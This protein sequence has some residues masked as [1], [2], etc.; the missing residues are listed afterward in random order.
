MRKIVSIIA[1]LC[2]VA[3]TLFA[4]SYTNNTYHKLAEEYTEK[5]EKALDA[6]YYEL[7][8][9]YA[10]EAKKNAALSEEFIA[11]MMAKTAAEES[12]EAAKARIDYA[13]KQGADPE[14]R[15]MK[16]ALSYLNQAE[17]DFSDENYESAKTNADRVMAVLSDDYLAELAAKKAAEDAKVNAAAALERA[18][19]AIDTAEEAGM[20]DT[21]PVYNAAQE[22]Y[23]SALKNF[24]DEN[25]ADSIEDSEKV[26][27]LLTPPEKI[28]EMVESAKQEAAEAVERAREALERAEA[29]GADKSRDPYKTALEDYQKAVDELNEGKYKAAKDDAQKVLDALDD[30]YFDVLDAKTAAEEAIGKAKARLDEVA[31]NGMSEDDP[32]YQDA[33][34]Y[35]DQAV[36]DF[37]DG[38]YADAKDNAEQ[39]IALLADVKDG[40]SEDVSDEVPV[41]NEETGKTDESETDGTDTVK[42]G[43]TGEPVTEDV[44][45]TGKTDSES[46]EGSESADE[47]AARA[48]ARDAIAKAKAAI[49]AAEKAGLSPDSDLYHK[50]NND[51]EKAVKAYGNGEYG[52][53]KDYAD[54]VVAALTDEAL[55]EARKQ[56]E[57]AEAIAAARERI[58]A[59]N[60]AGLDTSYEPYKE[61]IAYYR[62]AQKAFAEGDWD[63]AIENAGKVKDLL[64]DEAIDNLLN[65]SDEDSARSSAEGKLAAAR[66]RL[67]YAENA[68]VPATDSTYKAALAYY[69]RALSEFENGYYDDSIGDSEQVLQL[70]S[71]DFINNFL[72]RGEA[73]KAIAA[74]KE[75]IDYADSINAARDFPIAYNAAKAYYAQALNDY[76]AELYEKAVAD[77]NKAIDALSEIHEM[78]PLPKFYIVRPWAETKDC[79]WNISG[80]PYVYNN[81]WLWENLYEANKDNI[82]ERDNPNLILPGMKMEIPSITGEYRDGVYSPDVEYE[83]FRANR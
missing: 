47:N 6:G 17:S 34:D 11:M 62:E 79:F 24:E 38:A 40:K 16:S 52:P 75:R 30:D 23:T 28:A 66:E 13:S 69:D 50:V 51:Y 73:E 18:K 20:D 15:Q 68:G 27:D 5:A 44:A 22:A 83:T 74:A 37:A 4:V 57:A 43:E 53:A 8:E 54:S 41:D 31:A 77:A 61:A 39:V 56:A 49:A 65:E 67:D 58:V 48:A 78:I 70:L 12:I 29:A 19:A 10:A 63:A 26:V 1:A 25:Y 46:T 60:A 7:A 3:T 14:S 72:A 80:R 59:A 64:S 36:Q 42:E 21:Y 82:P 35:Y 71:D 2:I 9:E 81:P 45:D 55:A 32:L 33:K 76:N